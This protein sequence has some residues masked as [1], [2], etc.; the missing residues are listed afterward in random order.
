MVSQQWNNRDVCACEGMGG[1]GEG[2]THILETVKTSIS[3]EQVYVVL[4]I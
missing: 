3:L 2:G 4:M 1:G